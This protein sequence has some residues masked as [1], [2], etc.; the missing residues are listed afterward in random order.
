MRVRFFNPPEITL[1]LMRVRFFN[2][3][4]ITLNLVRVRFFNPPEITLNLFRI[5]STKDRYP[6]RGISGH[7]RMSNSCRFRYG[8]IGYF[9]GVGVIYIVPILYSAGDTYPYRR[10]YVYGWRYFT[11]FLSCCHRVVMAC[12]MAISFVS[13]QFWSHR[14]RGETGD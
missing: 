3:P 7:A 9:V 12:V 14:I 5:F 2:P 10:N 6:G 11:L 13:V 1:N 4:E 8:N